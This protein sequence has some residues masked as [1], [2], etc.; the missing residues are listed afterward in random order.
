MLG[1]EHISF[2]YARKFYNNCGVFKNFFFFGGGRG[3]DS[4]KECI[5][6]NSHHVS[7]FML[8]HLWKFIHNGPG[9]H[10]NKEWENITWNETTFKQSRSNHI[11]NIEM[12]P[13]SSK[14]QCS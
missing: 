10:K 5:L 6:V 9:E 12:R 13:H 8:P 1:K 2:L 14:V 3:L 4:K 11:N 7:V